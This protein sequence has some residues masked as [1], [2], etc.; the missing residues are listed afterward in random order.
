MIG[1][2]SYQVSDCAEKPGVERW[3]SVDF[4]PERRT[5]LERG[6]VVSNR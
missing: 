5:V 6:V 4:Q 2:A 1:K 3:W